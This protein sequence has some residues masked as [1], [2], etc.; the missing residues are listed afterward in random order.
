MDSI[1]RQSELELNM[2]TMFRGMNEEEKNESGDE[3][4]TNP[5]PLAGLDDIM[6]SMTISSQKDASP[7]MAVLKTAVEI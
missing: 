5:S 3:G 2:P 6:D 1:C 4:N 7:T